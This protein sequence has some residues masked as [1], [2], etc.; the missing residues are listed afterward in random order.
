VAPIVTPVVAST[1]QGEQWSGTYVCAQGQTD[2]V[3]T[4]KHT[5][6]TVLDA[7]FEFSHS[8]TGASGSLK[9]HGTLDANG[10][11]QLVPGQWINQPA[12]YRGV[13]LQGT[14][15]GDS[16]TGRVD[17]PSCSTFSLRRR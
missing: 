13:G 7:I 2:L 5:T 14:I 3:L 10:N 1:A 4:V 9:M 15:R 17:G 8:P 12:N 16:F 6:S 11:V